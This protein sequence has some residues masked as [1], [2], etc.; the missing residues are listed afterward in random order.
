[1]FKDLFYNSNIL[2][3]CLLILQH[4]RDTEQTTDKQEILTLSRVIKGD[5]S[6]FGHSTRSVND[7]CWVFLS[8]QLH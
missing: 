2:F 7:N 4:L 6:Q 1:M 3:L 5:Q 8:I